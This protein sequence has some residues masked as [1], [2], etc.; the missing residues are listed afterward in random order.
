MS[1]PRAPETPDRKDLLKRALVRMEQLESELRD[2]RA[3]RSEP[4]AIIGLGCR[5]PGEASDPELFEARLVEGF[6]AT[7]EIPEDRW[8]VDA[9]YDP[10]PDTPGAMYV[11][12]SAF[13]TEPVDG[14]DPSFFGIA[15]READEMDPQQRL[16]LEVVWEAL[17]RAGQSPESL[18]NS[19]TGVFLGMAAHDWSKM[20]G[21]AGDTEGIGTYFGTGVAHSVA[22][23]RIA[24]QLGLRGPAVTI[25]TACSSSLV[26]FHAACQSLR[27]QEVRM[28]IAAGVSLILAPDGH[29]IASRGRMLSPGGRCRT[30]DAAADGYVRGEGCGV[31]LVKRLSDARADGDRVL[32]LVRGTASNQDGRSGGLTA[33]SGGAQEDVIRTAL[34][35][36]G[37]RPEEVGY[38]EAH[39]TGTELGDPIEVHALAEVHRDRPVENPLYIGSVKTNIGHLEGAAGIAGLIKTVLALRSGVIPPHL[40][41]RVPNPH[42]A[43]D[44]APIRVPTEP[45]PWPSGNRRVAGVSSFGFSGTNAHVVLEAATEPDEAS[46]RPR[47]GGPHVVPISARSG[48][49]LEAL[50]HRLADRLDADEV[51]VA[52][53][54]RTLSRGRAGWE[55]RAAFVVRHAGALAESLRA[56][57]AGG[58][59]ASTGASVTLG[60]AN[61]KRP[62]RVAFLFTG[63]GAQRPG[64][65]RELLD[66]EPVFRDAVERC[67]ALFA[68]KLGVSIVDLLRAD[69]TD[70]DAAETLRQTR[71]TQPAL[72]TL[73]YGLSVLWR[74]W[75]VEP[76]VVLGHSVGEF[77]AATVAGVFSLE[78][79]ATLVAERARLMGELPE[80][81]G[82]ATVFA[83]ESVVSSRLADEDGRVS[84]AAVNGPAGT[85]VSGD[86]DALE[87]FLEGLRATGIESRRLSVSHGFHSH[88]M[89]PAVEGLRAVAAKVRH[90]RPE[91]DIIANRTGALA[92]SETFGPDY[93]AEH[94]RRPVLF[95]ASIRAMRA[96]GVTALLELGPAPVL[97]SIAASVPEAGANEIRVPALRPDHDAVAATR[98]AIAR[99]F[100]AGVPIDWDRVYPGPLEPVPLPTYPFQRER[101][102]FAP[103][104]VTQADE[105]LHP[106]LGRFVESPSFSAALFEARLSETAPAWLAEHRVF[107]RPIVPAAALIEM[108]RAAV[109][110][111]ASGEPIEGSA[112]RILEPLVVEEERIVQTIVDAD[113]GVVEVV[114]RDS[115]GRWRTHVSGRLAPPTD[116]RALRAV[117]SRPDGTPVDADDFRARIAASGV[118]YGPRFRG[119]GRIRRGDGWAVGVLDSS[120]IPLRERRRY[121][122]HP[123]LLDAAFQL[124]G[125]CLDLDS[126]EVYLPVEVEHVSWHHAGEADDVPDELLVEA[127]L[128]EGA[129]GAPVLVCDV[130]VD[131]GD[132]SFVVEGL[133]FQRAAS[134]KNSADRRV[135][136]WLY[137]LTWVETELGEPVTAEGRWA[138]VG[139][140]PDADA[141]AAALE[142]RGRSILR[143]PLGEGDLEF[144]DSTLEGTALIIPPGEAASSG[145]ELVRSLR[146][147]LGTFLD[148]AQRGA[149]SG[150]ICVVTRGAWAVTD[151]ESV[152]PSASAVWGMGHTVA[153]EIGDCRRIDLD[154]GAEPG[155][156]AQAILGDGNEDRL[157]LR[158]DQWHAARLV[159]VPATRD[160]GVVNRPTPDYALKSTQK[161]QLDGLELAPDAVG[162]P[163]P[164]KV[165]VRVEATGLNFRDVLNVLG[166]YPGDAGPLGSECVGIVEAKGRDV[167]HVSVGERVMAITPQGFCSRVNVAAPMT[168]SCPASLTTGEAAT[169]PIAFLTADW[170]LGELAHLSKGERVL[171]HAAAGGVGMAA[172][173]LAHRVG[174]EVFATAG[175]ERKRDVLRRMGVTRIYDS[176]SLD[177]REQILRDTDGEGVHVVLNSLADDFIPASIDVLGAQ[178]RFVEIGKTGVWDESRFR[179]VRPEADYHVLYLGEACE[180]EPERVH[181]RLA[182]LVAGF[183]DG[184]LTPL[185]HRAF[186]VDDAISAFRHMAQAKHIGKVV[187]FDSVESADAPDDGAVWITGGLGGL[188]LE[189]A[190]HLV[191][192][193]WRRIALTSR[194]EPTRAAEECL[195]EMR[196]RGAEVLLVRG[197]IS[198]LETV[199]GIRREIEAAG[200]SVR[201]V[202]H[203]AGVLDD[204]AI[205]GQSWA[206]FE[207]VLAPKVA[208]AWN[209]HLVTADLPLRSFVL[210]SAG[211]GLLGSP[212]QA[213][214][215]AANAYL[216][217]LAQLRRK[218][219]RPAVSIAWGPWAEVGMAARAGL[220]WSSSGLGAIDLE[221]GTAALRRVVREEITHAA[222]LPIDWT[223]FPTRTGEGA[224]IPFFSQVQVA[225][226]TPRQTSD[227]DWRAIL[228]GTPEAER[229]TRLE[230]LLAAEVVQ[231]LGLDASRS[232]S[233]R[234]VLNDLGM[235]SLMAVELSNRVGRGLDVKLPSTFV[236]EHSTVEGMASHLLRDSQPDAVQSSSAKTE[237]LPDLDV[238]GLS[239][240][241]LSSALL[242]ELDQIGS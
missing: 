4:L 62:P 16:L 46:A 10:D 166:M 242:D 224:V 223:R 143:L 99:L 174:A 172:V 171:I 237:P 147:S 202:I 214:Y 19:E 69:P 23:G 44:T 125:A 217:G 210:F 233:R 27:A 37:V 195:Q 54:A 220:D 130:A 151:D 228:D 6:D 155:R 240:E 73:G 59:S 48:P 176:R 199:L 79:A 7:T 234:Q 238:D 175:S 67:D 14:F 235:D 74:S 17:E 226:S 35:I 47:T 152:D 108:C 188:G 38:V 241:E 227:S 230:G 229:T 1:D 163:A 9:Y 216:D 213:N 159:R 81:G 200:W 145:D 12:R 76:S 70:V 58:A 102:W 190:R 43:W 65:G 95:E 168:I 150:R 126:D 192:R 121:P 5:F 181:R 29:V 142:E 120:L 211:A 64:M 104:R 78:D 75:G 113:G 41:F 198:D 83:E 219:G 164:G 3:Q 196:D 77:V 138:V 141:V 21:G 118:E 25:D 96:E 106:L 42:I 31:V 13:L 90:D 89:D 208:G 122:L 203:A 116:S 100:V 11:R 183:E 101:H 170:A 186:L 94:L 36:A 149:A 158:R 88:R 93:W 207:T 63:Q 161:G 178:G 34:R 111:V 165:R 193:G 239:E 167:D 97:L 84:V 105:G 156:V 2:L 124:C 55:H 129:P 66:A 205:H 28:A 112:M 212:G 154:M 140:G 236:F 123:A 53:L 26:A 82:M 218:Q 182:D 110:E 57:A 50:S 49:A 91:V 221:A 173:Q 85:V 60:E 8:D 157:A 117:T 131:G 169:I 189:T 148:I 103:H 40:H 185:P 133:R 24:Y 33:P 137:S 51:D 127:T 146:D 92:D 215:A 222:V 136:E 209:L 86:S 204:A 180:N 114:S 15:P 132:T 115:A 22:A 231:V 162:E 153:A 30:F 56:V 39:G 179:S 80:G 87:A 206:R 72:F 191:E 45:T 144:G 197:D 18:R 194:G 201:S 139:D 160:A 20:R 134:V 52:D 61:L 177:F 71:V 32:A 107:G 98:E 187:L 68:P 128:R 109:A 184:A 119:L 135:S 225:E 232:P